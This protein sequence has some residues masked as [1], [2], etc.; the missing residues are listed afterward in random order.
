M[1]YPP[2]LKSVPLANLHP[3]AEALDRDA[4]IAV[5]QRELDM[6][7][8]ARR[9]VRSRRRELVANSPAET[10]YVESRRRVGRQLDLD[11]STETL[12]MR[13]NALEQPRS[14][15]NRARKGFQ[16]DA[17]KCVGFSAN[18]SA[19]R[20][21]EELAGN[22]ARSGVVARINFKPARRI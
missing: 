1:R 12:E 4:A 19:D 7:T 14:K 15:S 2:G 18:R 13:S 16:F 22:A 17:F 5:A 10:M 6:S 21:S 20:R 11:A 3:T 9:R 8:V